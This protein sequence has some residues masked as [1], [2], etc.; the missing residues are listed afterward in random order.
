MPYQGPLDVFILL[1]ASP[2]QTKK[3][4][5]AR[6]TVKEVLLQPSPDHT[7]R[8]QEDADR[9]MRELLE[10]EEKDAAGAA[11]VSHKKSKKKKARGQGAS[12]G[13][14]PP[15][16]RDGMQICVK[17]LTGNTMR[18]ELVLEVESSDTIDMVKRMI[19][20]KEGI[21]SDQQCLLLAGK[22]LLEGRRTLADYNIKKDSTLHLLLR[23]TEAEEA[24]AAAAGVGVGF[25]GR[26]HLSPSDGASGEG[27]PVELTA[28]SGVALAA[29]STAALRSAA[30]PEEAPA[31][32]PAESMSRAEPAAAGAVAS[33]VLDSFQCPLTMEAMRDP[34]MTADG[35]TY[36]RTE[37]EKWFALGNRTSPLTGEELPSTN[38]LPNIAL[39]KAI[40][41]SELL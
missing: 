1:Q 39:R 14:S 35:Q 19:E 26:F 13:S 15:R 37:I 23:A 30:A 3:Q 6:R 7:K 5:G 27:V 38:L 40:R 11:A 20:D 36:E 24:G 10:E 12:T 41:E 21:R 9:A 25:M 22:Q 8:Q 28:A 32:A 16:V 31:P 17:T 33:F 29:A 2:E 4:T 18:L 34:V